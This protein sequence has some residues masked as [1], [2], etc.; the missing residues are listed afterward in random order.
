MGISSSRRDHLTEVTR[1]RLA[2]LGVPMF[3][4]ILRE[5]GNYDVDGRFKT[6]WALRLA[7]NYDIEEFFDRDAVTTSMVMKGIQSK[8]AKT[9][10]DAEQ[11]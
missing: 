1:A 7:A 8:K 11:S 10:S 4:L 2:N 5:P 3:H 6:K 9:G